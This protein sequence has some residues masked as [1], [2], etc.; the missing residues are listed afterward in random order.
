ML[1]LEN[2]NDTHVVFA[3]SS[4]KDNFIALGRPYEGLAELVKNDVSSYNN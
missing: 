2:S 1:I 3:I 4:I